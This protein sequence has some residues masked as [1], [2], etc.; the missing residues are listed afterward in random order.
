MA[1]PRPLRSALP[2]MA[3]EDA[4]RRNAM[5][6]ALHGTGAAGAPLRARVVEAEP[7][8][9]LRLTGGLAVRPL[10]VH[11]RPCA[12][13]PTAA[14]P[15]LPE[16]LAELAELEPLLLAIERAWGAP[17]EPLELGQAPPHALHVRVEAG[18]REERSALLLAVDPD[19]APPPAPAAPAVA[20]R[21]AAL[22]A[23]A[24]VRLRLRGPV[25]PARELGLLARGDLVLLP[26]TAGEVAA[27]LAW[28]G[29]RVPGVWSAR[30]G[31]F[32]SDG[33][34]GGG[35]DGDTLG[36]SAT[37]PG[38]IPVRLTAEL[39]VLEVPL[40]ELAR[41]A[42][43]AVLNLPPLGDAPAVRIAAGGAAVAAGRLVA[44]GDG[45]AVLV[46]EVATDPAGAPA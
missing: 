45:Y 12:W 14:S 39:A 28:A 23:R 16:A 4:A 40:A 31:R 32:A 29:R 17:L 8:P 37:A 15:L 34:Q 30:T 5:L 11:G 27:E 20:L 2:R 18:G 26:A 46:D 6:A 10:L 42:P 13:T 25:A 41:L 43:G 19:A 33:A 24:G 9:L 21:G 38:D 7:A 36:E 1:E 22:H 44:L 35:M 3:P